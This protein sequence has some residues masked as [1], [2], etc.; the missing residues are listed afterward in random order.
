MDKIIKYT[1]NLKKI[2]CYLPDE[3]DADEIFIKYNGNKIWPEE[4][5]IAMK[6]GAAVIGYNLKIDKGTVAEF[7]IWDYDNFTSND[8]LGT[9]RIV[10][11][12]VGGPFTSDMIKKDSGNSRYAI[13]WEI[14]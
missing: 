3:D 1:L 9:V 8:L 4:K 12:A 5:F 13:E 14:N 6:E 10:A 11:D 7:E 2:H